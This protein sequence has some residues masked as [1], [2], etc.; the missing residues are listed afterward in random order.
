[1]IAP[2]RSLG[3]RHAVRYVG[4]K[5]QRAPPCAA[6][7]YKMK[8]AQKKK[9]SELKKCFADIAFFAKDFLSR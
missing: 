4:T 2:R 6:F 3:G 9:R 5:S 8:K 1:L 7:F